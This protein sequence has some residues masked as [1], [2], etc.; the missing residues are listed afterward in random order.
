MIKLE[1]ERAASAIP[2]QFTGKARIKSKLLL[3]QGAR[4]G[5]VTFNSRIW[6]RAK[7][8]LK[9]ESA[10]KCAYC[11]APT[12]LVAHGDVEHFRPK[13]IYWWLAYCYDNYLYA[14]QICNET[15]KGDSFPVHG[16]TMELHPPLPT[17]FPADATKADLENIVKMFAPDPLN[18][19]DGYPMAKFIRA[20][21]KEKAGLVYPYMFD[22]EPLFKWEAEPVLKEVS[23]A[24]RNGRVTT[25]RIFRAEGEF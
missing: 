11:E 17:P 19:A 16:R 15:Y 9:K 6:K 7:I 14:C 4:E 23:L 25:R 2:K 1:R 24:P 21:T 10:G 18:D 13:S 22:P 20:V 8:Q 5:N 3:L 12:D